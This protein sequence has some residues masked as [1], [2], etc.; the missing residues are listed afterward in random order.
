MYCRPYKKTFIIVKKCDI[1]SNVKDFN[2]SYDAAYQKAIN[3]RMNFM[4]LDS[5]S[6]KIDRVTETST[7]FHIYLKINI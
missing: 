2:L 4:N 3:D 1:I 6:F 5:K 7:T